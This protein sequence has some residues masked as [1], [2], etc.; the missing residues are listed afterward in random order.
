MTNTYQ[1]KLWVRLPEGDTVDALLERIADVICGTTHDH[2][3]QP[4]F[5]D[6]SMS[7][8]KEA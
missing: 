7:A 6:W 1:V 4:C 5:Y 8:L 3:T 2:T